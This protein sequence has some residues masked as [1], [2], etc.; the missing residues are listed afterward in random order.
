[1]AIL[2]TKNTCFQATILEEDRIKE[3]LDFLD[4]RKS[5][6]IRDLVMKEVVKQE[7]KMNAL[8]FT[9]R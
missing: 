4:I 9:V 3:V 8:K 7:K 2:R 1:M 6:F 5:D